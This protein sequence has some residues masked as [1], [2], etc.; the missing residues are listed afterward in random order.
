MVKLK[1]WPVQMDAVV[2]QLFGENP[3]VYNAACRGDGSH[4]GVDFGIVL[5]TA[6]YAVDD[7]TAAVVGE[8]DTGYGKRIV[9]QH[10]GYASLYGHLNGFCITAGQSGKAGELIGYSGNTGWSEGPHLHF[11]T[12]TEAR[13]CCS[14]FDPWP[15]LARLLAEAKQAAPAPVGDSKNKTL[16]VLNVRTGPDTSFLDVGDIPAG[17]KLEPAGEVV[18]QG[19][20]EWLPVRLFVCKT[21]VD[22]RKLVG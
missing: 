7:W 16:A 22:G 6:V 15:E 17:V 3:G 10:E 20:R 12:R 19:G 21:D 2:T 5:G 4:N 14:C 8:D 13:R 1:H 11:E 9:L 18:K